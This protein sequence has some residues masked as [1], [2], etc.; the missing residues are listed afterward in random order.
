M[1]DVRPDKH[2][3]RG[4]REQLKTDTFKGAHD[5]GAGLAQSLVQARQVFA[6]MAVHHC[7]PRVGRGPAS[8]PACW[9]NGSADQGQFGGRGG[10]TATACIACEQAAAVQG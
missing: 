6:V 8:L 10:M 1:R 7:P 5:A 2:T 3:V 4:L 9:R